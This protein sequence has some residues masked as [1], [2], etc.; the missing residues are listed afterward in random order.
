MSAVGFQYELDPRGLLRTAPG[1]HGIQK[2]DD[3]HV[4][5][6]SKPTAKT[7]SSPISAITVG[8]MVSTLY[9]W[10]GGAPAFERLTDLFY[11]K[12]PQDPLLAPVFAHVGPAH[13]HHGALWLAEVFGGPGRYTHEQSGYPAMMRHHVGLA[14][15]EPQRRRWVQLIAETADDAGLPTDPE[16]RSAFI[17][18]LEWG[19]RIGLANSRPGAEPPPEAPVPLW[20][21]GEAPPTTDHPAE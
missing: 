21:W 11:R 6:G 3:V 8:T 4:G 13:A 20:G 5:R 12:V 7:N 14:I 10:A 19:S 18:Y 17:A 16:F 9:E 1:G 2:V 15:S